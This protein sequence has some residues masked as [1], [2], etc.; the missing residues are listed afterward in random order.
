MKFFSE[1]SE[2]ADNFYIEWLKKL[3]EKYPPD[4]YRFSTRHKLFIKLINRFTFN[5]NVKILDVGCG[6]GDL[7]LLLKKEL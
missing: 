3:G 7:L 6:P 5:K 4:G 1:T 2:H